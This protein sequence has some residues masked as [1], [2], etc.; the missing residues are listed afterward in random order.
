MKKILSIAILFVDFAGGS[1]SRKHIPISRAQKNARNP[2]AIEEIHRLK[3]ESLKS[4]GD[5]LPGLTA[6][7]M[8]GRKLELAETVYNDILSV[9][10]RVEDE[11]SLKEAQST[12]DTLDEQLTS[13]LNEIDQ[14]FP[15][16]AAQTDEFLRKFLTKVVG[17]GKTELDALLGKKGDRK[18]PEIDERI[19][20][21][22]KRVIFS[23][24]IAGFLGGVYFSPY[25]DIREKLKSF[26]DAL[27][28]NIQ[29]VRDIE[30]I[31]RRFQIVI[32]LVGEEES[33]SK[34]IKK[35]L[36][37]SAFTEV[38]KNLL[39]IASANQVGAD[40]LAIYGMEIL[41]L[42]GEALEALNEATDSLRGNSKLDS[43]KRDSLKALV[44]DVIRTFSL[45]K[46]QV[47]SLL[48]SRYGSRAGDAVAKL[49][50]ALDEV[51]A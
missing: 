46:D 17:D 40:A 27:T 11:E 26:D 2:S 8:F 20:H 12:M 44:K 7:S 14:L 35:S 31:K 15:G 22:A 25:W 6:E 3:K 39:K 37:G 43:M 18:S 9:A 34:Q 10:L 5:Q 24:M 47:K 38:R 51:K 33:L 13:K 23:P 19:T 49:I 1:G 48:L 41:T 36:L 29:Q 28:E 32:S 30:S 50:S 16:M 45:G 4:L 21:L 42:F